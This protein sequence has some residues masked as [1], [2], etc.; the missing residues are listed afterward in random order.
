MESAVDNFISLV[1]K[2][3][4]DEHTRRP[5]LIPALDAILGCYTPQNFQMPS[6]M[7]RSSAKRQRTDG[8]ID[9]PA[10]TPELIVEIKNEQGCDGADPDI[11]L[12]SYYTRLH[13]AN[14]NI[15][16]KKYKNTNSKKLSDASL[17]PALGISIIG[18]S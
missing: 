8:R 4:P 14:L 17:L 13:G 16:T 5:V 11:Q 12:S 1:C 2:Y 7:S 10:N 15:S 9:G 3:Y 18:K 6:L